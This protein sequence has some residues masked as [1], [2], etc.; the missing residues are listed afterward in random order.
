[1][2]RVVVLGTGTSVGKTFVTAALARELHRQLPSASV[3]ALKPVETGVADGYASDAR[4]LE[5][6]S[7]VHVKPSV[8]P[9][10]SFVEP[11]SPHLAA[12]RAGTALS[13]E[14]VV[15]WLRDIELAN[16]GAGFCLVETAGGAF[17]PFGET[18]TNTDLAIALEPALWVLIVPDALGALHDTRATLL[19][20]DSVA[21][22]PDYVVVNAAREPDAAT[23][24]TA[25]ELARL[26]IVRP[27]SILG[28]ADESGVASLARALIEANPG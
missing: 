3:L 15:A 24:T 20:L 6:V 2:K 17:S 8:H 5:S 27:V 19:A 21:R 7:H 26:R 9:L 10:Y 14:P 22:A 25:P 1:M 28:R 13:V 11:I 18:T 16:P 4:L 12:R 23:G